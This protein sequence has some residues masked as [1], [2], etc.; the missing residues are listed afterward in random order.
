MF[1]THPPIS[2]A[3]HRDFRRVPANH[4]LETSGDV[5]PRLGA[6]LSGAPGANWAE[7]LQHSRS[8][9]IR[10]RDYLPHRLVR[11]K[12]LYQLIMTLVLIWATAWRL[13][14]NML[15]GYSGMISFGH[16]AFFGVGGYTM[17][18]A[19]VRNSASYAMD[20]HSTWR[21]LS[22]ATQRHRHRASDV[23]SAWSLFRAVNAR[24]SARYALC[25]RMDGLPGSFA[26]DEARSCQ[27]STPN[28]A[29]RAPTLRSRACPPYHLAMI[30]SLHKVE[31]FAFRHG[32]HRYQA[33]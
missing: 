7:Q 33:E 6:R 22:A 1:D 2:I 25:V 29:T 19:F 5:R 28:L 10:Y 11:A 32:T 15:S 8:P 14:W 21:C 23:P 4:L 18:I 12:F 26:T 16:A 20:R 31:R 3:K 13:G 17:T 30:V 24:V 9:L 27:R